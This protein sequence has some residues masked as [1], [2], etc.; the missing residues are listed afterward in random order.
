MKQDRKLI[1]ACAPE[2]GDGGW[3]VLSMN[4]YSR[5][6]RGEELRARVCVH[7][8]KVGLC[9]ENLHGLAYTGRES[10]YF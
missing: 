2:S 6:P 9:P 10:R 1:D 3:A 7:I 5:A 4:L 8:K